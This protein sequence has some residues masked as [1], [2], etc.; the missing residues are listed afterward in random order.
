MGR[1]EDQVG[2]DRVIEQHLGNNGLAAAGFGQPGGFGEPLDGLLVCAREE[3]RT[4]QHPQG[5][6]PLSGIRIGVGTHPLI[7][8]DRL[9]RPAASLE[10]VSQG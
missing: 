2:R 9:A 5:L 7:H 1:T 4:T 8:L 3:Q 6:H 10:R